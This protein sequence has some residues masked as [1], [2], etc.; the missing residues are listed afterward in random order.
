MSIEDLEPTEQF[1]ASFNYH[2]NHWVWQTEG[3]ALNVWRAL[4]S[5]LSRQIAS[6]SGRYG[7]GSDGYCE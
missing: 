3:Y 2:A 1:E 7:L 5:V 6:A 4:D